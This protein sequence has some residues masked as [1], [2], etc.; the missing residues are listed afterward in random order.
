MMH[1][2]GKSDGPIVPGKPSNKPAC[3]GA[4]RVEGRGAAK[5]NP[6]ERTMLRTQ[7]RVRMQQALERVRQAAKQDR[8]MRFTALLHHVYHPDTLREAY[9]GLKREAAPGLDGVTWQDY[10]GNLEANLQ[11]LSGRLKR[12][13][14]RARPT[15]RAYIDKAD[16]RK[17]PLGVMALEDKIAQRATVEVLNAIYEVDFLGFSYGFRPGRSPHKALDALYVA[18]LTRKVNWVLDADICGFFDAIDRNWLVKFIEH[19]IGDRRVVRLI[20]KWLNAGVLEEG[21]RIQSEKGTVQGGSISPLL[22][23]VYLHYVFDLWVQQWRSTQARGE[24]VVVR[25]ADDFIV[26]F[27]HQEEAER[28]I[29]DLRERFAEFGLELHSEKTRLIEFGPWAAENRRR[30]GQGKPQTFDFLGF[31]HICGR[32]RSNG[33]FT[34]YRQSMR[35]RL[36]AKLA[37]VK[38]ELRRRMCRPV[39]EVG[40]WLATVLTGH[41]RYYGVPMNAEALGLFRYRLAWLWR[42]SLSRRSQK[43]RL[44]WQ[45]MTRLIDRY[46]PKPRIYHDYPLR[47]F[48]A[49][50]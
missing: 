44:P 43:G 48:G 31:T 11:E 1:G 12:G 46:L 50:T 49:I 30:K 42:R 2:Q 33:Y 27:Q 8:K 38:A 6:Q 17:R 18:Q 40:H 4:E 14:Y 23:N 35:Q 10:G 45:R 25:Y 21:E 39:P 26:G 28:F 32:K 20:Q 9:Y 47:R 7:G 24:V 36:Q 37:E 34:V 13:A 41:Y 5:G 22:A 19:R 16:G 3:A 15:R 29:E